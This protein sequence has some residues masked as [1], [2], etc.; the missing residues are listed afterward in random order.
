M[1]EIRLRLP[2]SSYQDLCLPLLV[3]ERPAL[4]GRLSTASL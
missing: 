4:I 3:A 2:P 1:V